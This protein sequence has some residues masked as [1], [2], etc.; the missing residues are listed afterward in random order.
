MLYNR[1]AAEQNQESKLHLALWSPELLA[2]LG[3][4]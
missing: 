3:A 1:A 4:R 2:K